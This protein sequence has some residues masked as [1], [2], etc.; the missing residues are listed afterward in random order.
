MKLLQFLIIIIFILFPFGELLRFDLGNSIAIR[1]LDFA[2]ITTAIVYLTL[3]VFKKMPF[4]YEKIR[5]FLPFPFILILSFAFNMFWLTPTEFMA[6]IFYLIRWIA[7]AQLVFIVI[8]FDS[9]FKNII[10]KFLVV[11][12]LIILLFGFIQY[13][14]YPSLKSLFYLGWDEHMYR[15]FST[16]FDPNYAGAFFVLYLLFIAGEFFATKS[17]DKRKRAVLLGIIM[18]TLLAVFLT[19]SRSALLM[20]LVGVIIFLIMHNKKKLIFLLLGSIVAFSLI[21]SPWFYVENIN[22]FRETSSAARIDNYNLSFRIIFDHPLLGVGFNTLRYVREE[23]VTNQN[24]TNAP[25]H[26]DAGVDNSFLFVA[27]TTGLLGLVAY[28]SLWYFILKRAFTKRRAVIVSSVIGL[29]VSSLFV[30]SLFFPPLML[31]LWIIIALL[32]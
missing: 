10:K 14:F 17:T 26:A 24:W 5:K 12:G 9:Q 23:Y 30:N 32:W 6:S 29:F 21:I 13:F 18:I 8:S 11:D 16:F 20:L 2:V 3:L 31:W 27:V 1:L 7:Y 15:M 22:L 25:S 28:V 19:F 4:H